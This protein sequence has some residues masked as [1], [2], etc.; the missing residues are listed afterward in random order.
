MGRIDEQDLKKIDPVNYSATRFIGKRGIEKV[1]ERTLHG[2]VGHQK[3]E[4]DAHGRIR[5]VLDISPP[6]AGQN[7]TVH[8][9]SRLQ[10]AAEGEALAAIDHSTLN[11]AAG[12][13][14]TQVREK[15]MKAL[16]AYVEGGRD[17]HRN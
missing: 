11:P 7:I 14:A 6:I 13:M 9:D 12:D 8:L 15:R 2:E 1:Y 10:R 16:A 4:I 3:A 5:Q 17:A